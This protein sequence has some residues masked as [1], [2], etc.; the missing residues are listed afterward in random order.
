MILDA[1]STHG[2]LAEFRQTVMPKVL[3]D[4]YD[5]TIPWPIIPIVPGPDWV[6]NGVY[7]IR[8]KRRPDR[9]WNFVD[10]YVYVSSTKMSKFKISTVESAEEGEPKVLIR[11]D[12]VRICPLEAR[13]GFYL[14]I[15]ED[16]DDLL[17]ASLTAAAWIFGE[18]L[19]GFTVEGRSGAIQWT[20]VHD[21]DDWELCWYFVLQLVLP[22]S[23]N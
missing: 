19:G 3:G 20:W 7:Y 5:P 16:G 22:D 8:D 12:L 18:L 13:T 17:K 6:N 4:I 10:P 9:C 23:I 1:M 21:G 15:G 11:S 2:A 14:G